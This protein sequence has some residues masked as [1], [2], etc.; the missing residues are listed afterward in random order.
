MKRPHY[1]WVICAVCTLLMFC[2][3]GLTNTAFSVYQPYLVA[4]NGMNNTQGSFIV[5]IRNLLG[6]IAALLV[7]RFYRR[8]GFRFGTAL[9]AMAAALAFFLFS[10]FRGLVPAYVSAAMLG[11]TYGLGGMVPVSILIGRWFR[12]SRS[13]AM[14][15]CAAGSGMA[16]VVVPPVATLLIESLGLNAA[17]RIEAGACLLIAGV[18]WLSLRD[19]PAALDLKPFGADSD[20]KKRPE[21]SEAAGMT[22]GV[23]IAVCASVALMGALANPAFSHLSMLFREEGH[24]A[25][26]ISALL[27]LMGFSLAAG[28]IIYGRMA[29]RL[30]AYRSGWIF[31][32]F[33][34]LGELLCALSGQGSRIVALVAM[35]VLGMGLPLCSVGLSVFARHLAGKE[36]Y[37]G[38]IK[39]FQVLY[40]AGGLA[41]GPIPGIFA[42][43]LG[44]YVPF[45]ALMV[46]FALT[47]AALMQFG[48]L[49]SKS[50]KA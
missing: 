41:F 48:I 4:A 38:T 7:D 28:K 43:R 44:S 3:V 35:V 19:D 21:D 40:Q 34:V 46:L 31:F 17:L 39:R 32:S 12:G 22:R 37:A 16:S 11:V 36:E 45:Y 5:T 8:T 6:L 23:R 18:A 13:Y 33:L 27:S 9:S 24:S 14:G 26:L 20:M 1:A 2:T 30:G 42:D 50:R 47:S 15:I 29:D 49:F 10:G 25:A